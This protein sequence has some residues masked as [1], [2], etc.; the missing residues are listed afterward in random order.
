MQKFNIGD[1][2]RLRLDSNLEND[3]LADLESSLSE[4][5]ISGRTYDVLAGAVE[6]HKVW[7]VCEVQ[8]DDVLESSSYGLQIGKIK[9]PFVVDEDDLIPST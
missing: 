4:R 3:L 5:D 9:T 6:G 7:T 2:V 8:N 1:S